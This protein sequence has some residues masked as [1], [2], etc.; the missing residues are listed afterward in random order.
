M[1]KYFPWIHPC[2]FAQ[3]FHIM[4][5]LRS[6]GFPFLV[7]KITPLWISHTFT[8][9]FSFFNNSLV[10]RTVRVF[11]FMQ[12]STYPLHTASTVKK[13]SSLTRIPVPQIATIT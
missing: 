12:I 13:G 10:K 9:A 8:Y 2:R 3:L 11:P 4:I 1:R 5:L 6:S 7:R